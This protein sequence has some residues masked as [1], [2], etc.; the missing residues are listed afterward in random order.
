MKQGTYSPQRVERHLVRRILTYAAGLFLIAISINLFV[1]AG[2]GNSAAT[3]MGVVYSTRLGI[4]LGTVSLCMYT[5]MVVI[6]FF[7]LG[8]DFQWI[9]L[10]QVPFAIFYGQ[11]IDLVALLMPA[12]T[13]RNFVEQWLLLLVGLLIV[14][15]GVLMFVGTELVP[16]PVEGLALAI[17]MKTKFQFH[18]CKILLDCTFAGIAIVSSLVFFKEL[19]GVGVGTVFLAVATGWT[20]GKLKPYLPRWIQNWHLR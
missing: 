11:S 4:P 1:Y 16:M 13:P 19:V 3:T 7:M 18:Q 8:K 6:Q 17:S 5:A 20:M 15:V 12:I 10:W 2:L 9:N 14:S